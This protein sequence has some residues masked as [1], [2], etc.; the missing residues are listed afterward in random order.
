MTAPVYIPLRQHTEF[1]I[2]DGT[3]RIKELV[4]K[5][6]AFGLPAL[7]ISDLMNTFGLVKFYKACRGAGI[8]PVVGADV[9]VANPENP[10]QPF[11]AMLL[12]R[13]EAGYRRLCELLTRA[14]VGTDRNVA[15]AELEPQWLAEGDNEGLICLSGAH[16]GEVGRPLM[17]VQDSD[18]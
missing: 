18:A 9:W 3:L 10:E 7:G 15:H 1:S 11:R 2:T 6:A 13:N 8:K 14:Y 16:L 4:K 12:V 17:N 5:A